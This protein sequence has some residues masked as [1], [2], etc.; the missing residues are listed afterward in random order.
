MRR[1][2]VVLVLGVAAVLPLCAATVDGLRIHSAATGSG[3]TL[4]FVH[5]WTCDSSSWTGQVPAFAKKYRVVTLDLPGH[6]QSGSP[7]DGKFSIDL[8]ARAV[9]AVRAETKADR[10]V[11]VGHSMGAPVIRQYARRYPQHVAGLVAVDGPLDMSQFG[12]GGDGPAAP[13]PITGPQGLAIREKMIRSMFIP[14]TPEPLQ[15]QILTM[16]LKAPE[17]TAAGAMAAMFDPAVRVKDVTAVPALAVYAGTAQMPN[18]A[19]TQKALPKFEA[20]QI[21]GTG[22]FLMMEK[23]DE[24][25][26]TLQAFLDTIKF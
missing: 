17:A 16:M 13:P 5:G 19:E 14:Q 3:P 18:V 21:A 2:L 25:N 22:H 6:G 8:F 9:E 23:P 12:G 10:I 20:A 7:A 15:K 1:L 11:L 26:R 24:F 4:V